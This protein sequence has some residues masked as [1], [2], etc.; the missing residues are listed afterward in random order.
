MK[1]MSG[2]FITIGKLK[3]YNVTNKITDKHIKMLL[4]LLSSSVYSFVI[5]EQIYKCPSYYCININNTFKH[6]YE[7][8]LKTCYDTIGK[9]NIIITN[10]YTLDNK[11]I[12]MYCNAINM[13]N[14][15]NIDFEIEHNE[16]HCSTIIS[17]KKN[18][19]LNCFKV[20]N[21]II[22]ITSTSLND[23]FNIVNATYVPYLWNTI[24]RKNIANN[25]D[26]YFDINSLCK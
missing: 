10:E 1:I 22:E 23:N 7:F 18:Y 9:F 6:T 20:Y 8:K 2:N 13:D 4:T 15:I 25:Y 19:H 12:N 17:L 11:N 3:G 24:E 26:Y 5:Y 14:L 16:K 21:I